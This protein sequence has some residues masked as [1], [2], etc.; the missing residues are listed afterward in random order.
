MTQTNLELRALEEAKVEIIEENNPNE[1]SIDED[2]DELDLD[3][4]MVG[5]FLN[6]LDGARLLI[7]EYG[8]G[9]MVTS[10]IAGEPKLTGIFDSSLCLNTESAIQRFVKPDEMYSPNGACDLAD[11]IYALLKPKKNSLSVGIIGE[12]PKGT[13][14]ALVLR[15]IEGRILDSNVLFI[16][17]DEADTD[18]SLWCEDIHEE[19]LEE[20]VEFLNEYLIAV[21]PSTNKQTEF[22]Q[23]GKTL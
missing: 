15:D 3:W 10:Q 20:V 21:N 18:F 17:P 13:N 14:L 16:G 6:H 9:G 22:I 19:I 12:Y 5:I 1:S 11:S 7:G 8:I 23:S 4:D 2:I